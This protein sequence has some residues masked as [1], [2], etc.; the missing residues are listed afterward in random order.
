MTLH[1]DGLWF[2]IYHLHIFLILLL[3]NPKVNN[4]PIN[5]LF[6]FQSP[7]QYLFSKAHVHLPSAYYLLVITQSAQIPYWFSWACGCGGSS[8]SWGLG[9][10][11]DHIYCVKFSKEII[12]NEKKKK[13]SLG[14]NLGHCLVTHAGTPLMSHTGFLAISYYGNVVI[15]YSGHDNLFPPHSFGSVWCR[16]GLFESMPHLH[17][18]PVFEASVRVENQRANMRSTERLSWMTGRSSFTVLALDCVQV[19][20]ERG[21][22]IQPFCESWPF[23]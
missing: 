4:H 6:S 8:S 17:N 21:T 12:K 23:E 11:Y 9:G 22:W 15:K 10:Q 18:R 16:P 3:I 19:R 13:V 2:T 5:S 7:C 14:A 20:N 1:V